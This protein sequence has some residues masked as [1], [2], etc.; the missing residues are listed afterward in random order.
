MSRADAFYLKH[1]LYINAG[2]LATH[3]NT[4]DHGFRQ[5]DVKFYIELLVNWMDVSFTK[6]GLEI[7]NT[8]I[9]R[10]L[11]SLTKEGL[12]VKKLHKNTPYY[13]FS[14]IGLL[15]ITNRLVKDDCL[16]DLTNFYFLFH[17]VHLYAFKCNPYF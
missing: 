16:E 8:Q 2:L 13:S 14:S 15:E 4:G 11:E 10:Q 1:G 5:R 12:L 7:Q 3:A 6:G 17:F 9:Q